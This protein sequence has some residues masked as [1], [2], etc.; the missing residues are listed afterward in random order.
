MTLT[1]KKMRMSIVAAFVGA[2]LLALLPAAPASANHPG[3]AATAGV[4]TLSGGIGTCGTF[5]YS[6]AGAGVNVGGASA[7]VGTASANGSYCNPTIVEGTANGTLTVTGI[8]GPSVS[9]NFTWQR[10]GLVALVTFTGPGACGGTAIAA[11]VPAGTG[12]PT[13]AAVVGLG[14]F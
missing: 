11:F 7:T 2:M 5:S 9:C 13:T 10:T 6:G 1:V 12:A 3:A 14:T 4:A 8:V